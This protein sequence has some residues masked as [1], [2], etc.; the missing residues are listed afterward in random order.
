M[1][2]R[3]TQYSETMEIPQASRGFF[4]RN[5][6][7]LKTTHHVDIFFPRDQR[8]G[9]YQTMVIKGGPNA[10]RKARVQLNQILADANQEYGEYRSRMNRRKHWERKMTDTKAP[11][12]PEP[13]HKTQKPVVKNPFALLFVDDEEKPKMKKPSKKSVEPKEEFPS[14][15][16]DDAARKEKRQAER[17]ERIANRKETKDTSSSSTKMDYAAAASKETEEVYVP[18]NVPEEKPEK[19]K[20]TTLNWGDWASM[21]DDDEDWE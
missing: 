7:S 16:S 15:I 6:D 13:T 8:S 3:Q 10:I 18:A 4:L 21:D 20:M 9:D 2:Y 17:R 11:S 12:H 19:P 14:L 1:A 5:R